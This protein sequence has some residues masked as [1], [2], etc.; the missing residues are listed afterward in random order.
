MGRAA[1]VVTSV[2]VFLAGPLASDTLRAAVL[3]RAVQGHAARLADHAICA[4]RARVGLAAAPGA[5]AEG[6]LVTLGPDEAARLGFYQTAVGLCPGTVTVAGATATAHLLAVP[7]AGPWQAASWAAQWGPT[8]AATAGDVMALWP[9]VPARSVAARYGMM[10][11]HGASRVRAAAEASSGPCR[12]PGPDDLAVARRRQ[13]YARFFAVEEYDLR[14]RRFNGEMSPQVN[15]AVF[16]SGDAVTVLPYDP[17]RDRVLLVEQFRMGPFA[18]GD[19]Q[20]WLL[21][22]IAGRVDPGETPEDTAR[23]EAVEEAGLALGA[24]LPVA[25]YYPTPGAKAEYLY[26]F[27]AIADLPDGVEGVFGIEGEAEDIRGHLVGFHRLMDLVA[28][29]AVSNGPLILTALWLQRERDG[30]RA[31]VSRSAP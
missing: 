17:V 16:L 25:N 31:A 30:L 2:R 10:L 1:V 6:L 18:R 23:R 3:G 9:E 28:S 29:G 13:V 21:E 27:V 7:D 24:V 4:D 8:V 5:E 12:R 14:Y 22:P 20:P 26:S 11:V 15:R 19:G